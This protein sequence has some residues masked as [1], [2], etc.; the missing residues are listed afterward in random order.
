MF[1]NALELDEFLFCIFTQKAYHQLLKT[2]L[3]APSVELALYQ[4]MKSF[5]MVILTFIWHLHTCMW[6]ES[7]FQIIVAQMWYL[8]IAILIK[9]HKLFSSGTIMI[10]PQYITGIQCCANDTSSGAA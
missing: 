4:L 10:V 9:P 5:V 7:T 3:S 2:V 1:L 6:N 8:H